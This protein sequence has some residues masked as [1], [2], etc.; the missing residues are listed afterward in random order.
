MAGKVGN[1]DIE[2]FNMYPMLRLGLLFYWAIYKLWVHKKKKLAYF[3]FNANRRRAPKSL[4]S[5]FPK[6]I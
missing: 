2:L 5:L 3:I 6:N 1:R 4:L